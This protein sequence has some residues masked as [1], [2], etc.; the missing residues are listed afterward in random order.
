MKG[1]S[2]FP[3]CFE[4]ILYVMGLI[5]MGQNV[6]IIQVFDPALIP[7]IIRGFGSRKVH[8]SKNAES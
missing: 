2:N 8:S 3:P 4:V 7:T 1:L 6:V 5:E